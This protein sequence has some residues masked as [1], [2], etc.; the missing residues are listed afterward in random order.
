LNALLI[1]STGMA[2]PDF[3]KQF[4]FQ[5]LGIYNVVW[6]DSSGEWKNVDGVA[7]IHP[8]PMAKIGQ[9]VLQNGNWKGKQILPQDWIEQSTLKHVSLDFNASWGNGYGYLWWLSEVEI[10]DTQ[11]HSISA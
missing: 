7:L 3:A 6:D 11:V 5:H 8:R 2:L 1:K 4:L 10:A 9:L